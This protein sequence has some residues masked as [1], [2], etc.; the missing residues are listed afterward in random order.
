MYRERGT[1]ADILT[2]NVR[3]NLNRFKTLHPGKIIAVVKADAYGHGLAR[4]VPFL[5]DADAFAVA[6]IEEALDLRRLNPDK[7]IILLE[8]VFNEEELNAAIKYQLDV[9]VHQS[10]QL[11][12]LMHAKGQQQQLDVWLKIDTG[13]SRLGFDPSEAETKLMQLKSLPLVKNLR[14]MT[15]FASSDDCSAEQTQQQIKMNDWVKSLGFEYSFSNTGAVLNQISEQ[16][17][18]ARVGIGLYGISPL[19]DR[20][21]QNFDLKPVMKLKA[22]VIATKFIAKGASVG[23][24][25][26]YRAQHDMF[27]G[28]VGMGYADGYPWSEKQSHVII[29]EQK[30]AVIGRVSMDMMAVD[31]TDLPDVRTGFYVEAWGEGWPIEAVAKELGLIPYTLTCGITNR[32]NF[33]DIQ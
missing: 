6:T 17:E 25:G 11:A 2:A 16:C 18:W 7:K 30:V 3:H 4:V 8:G 33:N 1:Q 24:G 21:G 5:R 28:I 26:T 19:S 15:H 12:L 10:Y 9:V 22:K 23:Y 14:I 32:V 20:W 27:I 13:M 29:N 31:L